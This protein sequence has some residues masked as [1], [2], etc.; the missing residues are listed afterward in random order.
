[1]VLSRDITKVIESVWSG[2][3]E[4]SYRV[5]VFVNL[6]QN[7]CRAKFFDSGVEYMCIFYYTAGKRTYNAIV[8]T[9]QNAC[10]E[11]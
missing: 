9:L 7:L 5:E 1:M 10:L 2:R 4:Y 6:T 3:H 11:I 8:S